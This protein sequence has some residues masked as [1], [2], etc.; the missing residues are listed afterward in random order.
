MHWASFDQGGWERLL[1][2][3]DGD[4]LE[5]CPALLGSDRDVGAIDATL[6][7]AQAAGVGGNIE[8]V[9]RTVSDLVVPSGKRGWVV[10]NPPYGVRV[11]GHV[12]GQ[13]GGASG[14]DLRDLYAR[15]G[16]VLRERAAGWH[17]AVLGA[18]D[19]PI[20]QMRLPLAPTFTF[21]NGGIEVA[22]HTGV[23]PA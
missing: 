3:H 11:G 23:V 15:F 21:S 8:V 19:T 6:D 12:A 4:V 22:A 17:V 14:G 13:V 16:A 2:G 5:R 7:N 1:K 20:V 10:T 9:R 18:R